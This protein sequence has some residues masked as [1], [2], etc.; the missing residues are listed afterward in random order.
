MLC[1]GG[2]G[3][4]ARHARLLGLEFGALLDGVEEVVGHVDALECGADGSGVTGV[5][6]RDLHLIGPGQIADPFEVAHQ[7][8]HAE[9]RLEE[10]GHETAADVPRRAGH[11]AEPFHAPIL[12]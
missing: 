6:H 1:G 10:S 7:H 11:Q 8:A 2:L 5:P 3:E 9:A 12:A 4:G